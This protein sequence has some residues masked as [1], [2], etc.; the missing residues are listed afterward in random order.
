MKKLLLAALLVFGA[1]GCTNED[2]SRETL[3]KYGFTDINA[4]GYSFFECG[5]DYTYATKFTAKNSQGVYDNGSVDCG[6]LNGCTIKF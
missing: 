6:G 1:V 3:Q 4:G 5:D 2:K